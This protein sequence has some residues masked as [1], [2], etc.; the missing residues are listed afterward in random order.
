[1][2]LVC[3]AYVACVKENINDAT[4]DGKSQITASFNA[5]REK[6]G[7][8]ESKTVLVDPTG[9]GKVMLVHWAKGDK[10]GVY[11][12]NGADASEACTRKD[13]ESVTFNDEAW[14]DATQFIA[15]SDGETSLFTTT[16]ETFSSD[17]SEYL[18]IYPYGANYYCD[19]T[20][21]LMRFY[22]SPEQTATV[23]SYQPSRGTAVAKATDLNTKV[24]FR[25]ILSLLKFT[26]PEEYDGNFASISVTVNEG[27]L[28]GDILCDFSGDSPLTS[29]WCDT[30][31][32]KSKL[33]TVTLSSTTGMVAGDYYIVVHPGTFSGLTVKVSSLT[34]DTYTRS[35]DKD[36]SFVAGTIHY[37]GKINEN[38]Y[39]VKENS[40]LIATASETSSSTLA[41]SWTY[42][43]TVAGDISK[44]YTIA[45]YK[46]EACKELYVSHKVSAGSSIWANLTPKFCFSGLDKNTTY[47]F[48]VT[49]TENNISSDVVPSKTED[50]T[51]VTMSSEPAEEGVVILAEDFGELSG[52]GESVIKAA[53]A[54]VN[55]NVFAKVTGENPQ[56]DFQKYDADGSSGLLTTINKEALQT[57]RLADWAIYAPVNKDKKTSSVYAHAG[58]VKLGIGDAKSSIMTPQLS[59]IPEG[60]KATLEIKVT[61]A[62]RHDVSS[63]NML[64]SYHD[65]SKEYPTDYIMNDIPAFKT[66]THANAG[67]ISDKWETYTLTLNNVT[68]QHRLMIGPVKSA[69]DDKSRMYVNDVV[70]TVISLSE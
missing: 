66:G 60:K 22:L 30:Y 68:N 27:G 39:E 36:F 55:K 3:L 25:N 31:S 47:Y 15:Q 21:S 42:G 7:S 62:R 70:V 18:L 33:K 56:V 24:R 5:T 4:N 1:M 32:N 13:D 9:E 16:S 14:K 35:T 58:F 29:F 59:A 34:G 64:V 44:P 43:A 46:D 61:A 2:A 40:E 67:G 54:L 57:S 63:L 28:A 23:G 11:D 38:D 12:D 37:M 52:G 19:M 26:V 49:D 48:K 17:E 65:I 10:I 6:F 41:F 20:Q 8:P 53:T 69:D 50:F 45:L 51:I